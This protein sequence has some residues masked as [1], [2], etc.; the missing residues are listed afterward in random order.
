MKFIVDCMLGKLA[1]WLKILGFDAA[2]LNKAEDRDLLFLARREQRVLLTKDQE[3]LRAAAALPA[4]F[5]ES[6]NWQE[7]LA[8]VIDTFRLRQRA[9]PHSRCLLCNVELKRVPKKLAKNLVTPF[10]FERAPSF[11]VCPSCGR[12]FWPGTH[13]QDM[14]LKIAQVLQRK[15]SPPK[16]PRET[17]KSQKL[18]VR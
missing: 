9:K 8:Q 3:L 17:G 11:A 4:L 7:Q 1:K 18:P 12:V 6:D 15:K 5:I 14:D 10:V 13:F 16:K 2:Y